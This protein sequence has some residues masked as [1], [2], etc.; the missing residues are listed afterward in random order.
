[1]QDII[2]QKQPFQRMKVSR[3]LALE[4]F[5][6][7]KYKQYFIEKATQDV[8]TVTLYRCGRLIDFCRGP[9]LPNTGLVS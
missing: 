1:M 3:S 5:K 9:H 6:E 4:F 2:R 7:N 8:D